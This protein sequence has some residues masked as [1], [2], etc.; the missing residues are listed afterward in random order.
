MS[1]PHNDLSQQN[2]YDNP[3]FFQGYKTLR[4]QDSGLNGALELPAIRALLPELSHLNVLDLGSGFGDFARYARTNGASHVTGIEL[5]TRML[6][7]AQRLTDDPSIIFEHISMED[8]AADENSYDLVVSSLALH[9]V[10][11]YSGICRKVYNALKPGGHF[12]FSVEH[13]VCTAWPAGWITTET[14]EHWPLD[15]YH[16][17][18]IRHTKWFI[19]D[20]IKYHRTTE[21]YVNTLLSSGFT[22][23]ALSEPQPTEEALAQRPELM[24]HC[25]R[26]PF[27]LLKAQK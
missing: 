10:E 27:L 21:N 20:V 19:N 22:L 23:R 1:V 12:I 2:V 25:R 16:D 8:F 13:P 6:A 3:D 26:P 17:Q 15:N 4:Q 7:E 14:G 5:S 18:S 11:D 9:Y 24:K